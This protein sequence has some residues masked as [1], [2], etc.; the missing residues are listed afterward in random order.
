MKALRPIQG[1][2]CSILLT[3]QIKLR[4][5][6]IKRSATG[7]DTLCPKCTRVSRR[8][9]VSAPRSS[10]HRPW[11]ALGRRLSLA[12]IRC[13]QRGFARGSVSVIVAALFQLDEKTEQGRKRGE[14][15]VRAYLKPKQANENASG[16]QFGMISFLP[17][18]S[19]RRGAENNPRRRDQD[20]SEW[21]NRRYALTL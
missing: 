13:G 2:D 16:P 19:T 11:L 14:A 12:A 18:S 17:I 9:Q 20:I 6:H 21:Q 3:S 8:A 4:T 5:C 1:E 10:Q 7:R 15:A